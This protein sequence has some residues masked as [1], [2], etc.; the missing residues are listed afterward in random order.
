M[1]KTTGTRVETAR[2]GAPQVHEAVATL[3]KSIVLYG[4]VSA[5]V[6]ATVAVLAIGG[7]AVSSFMWVRSALLLAVTVLIHRMAVAVAKGSRRA[8]ERVSALTVV[9]PVAIVGVDAI[10]GLCPPWFAVMQGV[11]A[12]AL[13]LAAVTVRGTALRAVFPKN[14]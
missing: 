8:Y 7:H 5:V 14:G 9:L 1:G 4:V 6:L 12:L 10:P 13:V 3:K 2:L 11:S